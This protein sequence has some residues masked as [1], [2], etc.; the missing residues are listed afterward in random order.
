M[1][2]ISTPGAFFWLTISCLV[3][4]ATRIEAAHQ[5]PRDGTMFNIG[6]TRTN[7]RSIT[8]TT[9]PPP[10]GGSL[11]SPSVKDDL[12]LTLFPSCRR[13]LDRWCKCGADYKGRE[14]RN[15]NGVHHSASELVVRDH[16]RHRATQYW[17]LGSAG[18]SGCH[19]YILLP[20]A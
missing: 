6:C 20:R 16:D 15:I 17:L 8:S 1:T 4:L 14:C 12:R 19:E 13:R 2:V 11:R 10:G 18:T 9:P 7:P 3:L 5:C